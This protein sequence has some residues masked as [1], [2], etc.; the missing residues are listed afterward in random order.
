MSYFN[1]YQFVNT[2]LPRTNPLFA[3]LMN[4][5]DEIVDKVRSAVSY[6]KGQCQVTTSDI[7]K[8]SSSE[9]EQIEVC[10]YENFLREN[11]NYFGERDT[12][13]IDLH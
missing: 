10:L 3:E 9:K 7:S 2:I 12:I 5:E 6:C 4:K 1:K 8:I 13:F 11:R